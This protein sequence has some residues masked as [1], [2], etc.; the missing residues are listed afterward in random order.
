M[1]R[2]N[3]VTEQELFVHTEFTS[4]LFRFVDDAEF[5]IDDANKV[6]HVRSASRVGHSD[7]GVNRKRV[8]EIRALFLGK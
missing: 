1:K 2:S 6:I 3:I 8:E 5:F 4:A 7:M